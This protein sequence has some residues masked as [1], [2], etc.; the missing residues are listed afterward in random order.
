MKFDIFA[1]SIIS[2]ISP[3]IEEGRKKKSEKFS[4]ISVNGNVLKQKVESG[5]LDSAISATLAGRGE[6]QRERYP[7]IDVEKFKA[8]LLEI[9]DFAEDPENIPSTYRDLMDLI[10]TAAHEAYK[11][12]GE[13]RKTLVANL[14]KALLN[15]IIDNTDAVTPAEAPANDEEIPSSDE[16][17]KTGGDY[18]NTT[19]DEEDKVLDF[20]SNQEEPID[21][22]EVVSYI[23]DQLYLHDEEAKQLIDNLIEKKYIGR[24]LE[25]KLSISVHAP[26][27]LDDEED[28]TI[29]N[30]FA[31]SS[32]VADTFRRTLGTR[33]F[34]DD[35]DMSD[36]GS[37]YRLGYGRE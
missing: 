24:N 2:S 23:E 6:R 3:L 7:N 32:D 29:H 34:F 10:E 14:S 27:D 11:H 25:N 19:T 5:E 20:I 16:L 4:Y 22:D 18:K 12:R 1:E 13:N 26:E 21:Y 36:P 31:A 33:D 8:M 15:V 17:Q 35:E 9:A 30:P 37:E 28:E